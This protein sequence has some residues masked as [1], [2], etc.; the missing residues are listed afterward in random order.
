MAAIVAVVIICM[1]G[2]FAVSSELTGTATATTYTSTVT[3]QASGSV[4]TVFVP[5]TITNGSAATVT[6]TSTLTTT[7]TTTDTV[8]S[9]V[10]NV[11]TA[12]VTI[13]QTTTTTTTASVTVTTTATVTSSDSSKTVDFAVSYVTENDSICQPPSAAQCVWSGSISWPTSSCGYLYACSGISI[14]PQRANETYEIALDDCSPVNW[15]LS[16]GTPPNESSLTVTI[17]NSHGTVLYQTETNASTPSL[18]GSYSPC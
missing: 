12:T 6:Q 15:S 16:M 14:S 5:T 13:L 2:I 7:A 8:L 9:G 3:R 17:T 4:S 18:T 11:T 10:L 1:A